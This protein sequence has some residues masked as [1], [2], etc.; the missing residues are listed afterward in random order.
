MNRPDFGLPVAGAI[1]LLFAA[2]VVGAAAFVYLFVWEPPAAYRLD[3]PGS[4]WVIESVDGQSVSEPLPVVRFD[5]GGNSATVTVPCGEAWLGWAW[6][7]D[8]SAISFGLNR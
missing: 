4:Q 2:G 1:G 6:D 3:L 8:G 7:T 5:E